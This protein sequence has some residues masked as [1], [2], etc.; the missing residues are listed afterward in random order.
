MGE[1]RKST[2]KIQAQVT[3]GSY[4]TATLQLLG[5]ALTLTK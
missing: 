2:L 4:F 1:N 3:T 5:A